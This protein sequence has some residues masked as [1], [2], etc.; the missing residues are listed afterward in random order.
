MQKTAVVITV[1]DRSYRGERQ[2]L[3][4]PAVEHALREAGFEVLGVEI[5]PD[6]Q[7][8]ISA[9]LARCTERAA[10]AVT[11]GGTG[12]AKRDVTPEATIAICERL[13]PGIP[14]VMRSEGRKKNAMAPLSRGVCGTRG[15]CLVLNLPGS[16]TGAVESLN[17]VLPLVLH[18]MQL[19]GGDTEHPA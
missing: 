10:L 2:D 12:V 9:A 8:Q 1:S 7:E 15:S 5:V 3:S 4:G 6:D 18:A 11:T 16:P 14:E 17:A 13:I 19:L